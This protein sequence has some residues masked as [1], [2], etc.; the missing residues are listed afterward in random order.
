[1]ATQA[2]KNT[3]TAK[4]EKQDKTAVE[5]FMELDGSDLVIPPNALGQSNKLRAQGIISEIDDIDMGSGAGAKELM[6]LLAD[7][8]DF[9]ADN[10]AKSKMAFAE[11]I[12]KQDLNDVMTYVM[13][14]F[15]AVG[16]A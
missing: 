1:M 15:S 3:A 6:F 5:K 10:A 16:E 12:D 2:T 8:T 4:E 13:Y 14:Y 11:F 7:A 9:L